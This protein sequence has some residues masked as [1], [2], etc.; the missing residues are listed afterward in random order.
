MIIVSNTSPITNLAA[1][2]RLDLLEKLYGHVL[3]PEAVMAE[4]GAS[5]A[6]AGEFMLI[7]RLH[8]IE[9]R[10]VSNRPVVSSL[11]LELDLGEAEAIALA[12][13][14]KADLL[15]MDERRGR[16]AAS[17]LGL[18]VLGL[19]GVLMDAKHRG[20]A[21]EIKPILD[22]LI[23]KAGFWINKQLYSLVIETAGEK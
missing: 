2:E 15:L 18:Q 4:M 20:F 11:L 5:G 19:L 3:V 14:A 22:A 10:E 17:H 7:S 13:E 1:I 8:W 12:M 9:T 16:K 6:D 23:L 21:D